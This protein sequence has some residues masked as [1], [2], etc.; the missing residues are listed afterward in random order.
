MLNQDAALNAE[1]VSRDPV[2]RCTEP[3]KSAMHDHEVAV[4]HDQAVFVLQRWRQAVDEVEE[5]V[6]AWRNVRAVLDVP[7]RPVPLRG[8]S[9]AG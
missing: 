7:G 8:C 3:G 1:N 2:H 6:A 9:R 5:T 4:S